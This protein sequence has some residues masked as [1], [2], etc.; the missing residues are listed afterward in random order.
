MILILGFS[1]KISVASRY[2][3]VCF[4]GVSKYFTDG[5]KSHNLCKHSRSA[6]SGETLRLLD[7][8]KQETSV[9]FNIVEF[10]SVAIGSAETEDGIDLC[11]AAIRYNSSSVSGSGNKCC[12]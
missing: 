10:L 5:I 4:Q 8:R 7:R 9:H 2:V 1:G 3:V 6:T 12:R 11:V